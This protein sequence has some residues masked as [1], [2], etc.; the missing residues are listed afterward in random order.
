MSADASL[1]FDRCISPDGTPFVK[2]DEQKAKLVRRGG[3]V[4][5]SFANGKL[6]ERFSIEGEK[7]VVERFE[8]A[9]QYPKYATNKGEGGREEKV[10]K[11]QSEK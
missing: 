7:L 1:A 3:K 11:K 2:K 9:S 6:V 5:V 10:G 4:L 8:P